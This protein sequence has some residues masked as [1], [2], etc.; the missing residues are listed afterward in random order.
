MLTDK[1]DQIAKN[2]DGHDSWPKP[3]WA[4]DLLYFLMDKPTHLQKLLSPELHP[5]ITHK[6]ATFFIAIAIIAPKLMLSE[7]LAGACAHFSDD[8]VRVEV[9]RILWS[10]V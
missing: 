6:F 1:S 9:G 10:I 2:F 3:R 5:A 7:T 8:L 4:E